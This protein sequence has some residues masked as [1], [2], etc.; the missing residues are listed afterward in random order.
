MELLTN[1]RNGQ[2]IPGHLP[3]RI[4]KS[5]LQPRMEMLMRKMLLAHNI[6]MVL[7]ANKITWKPSSGI[8]LLPIRGMLMR[9]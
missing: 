7:F 8:D 5:V 1:S 3:W 6:G 2:L 4:L 9:K